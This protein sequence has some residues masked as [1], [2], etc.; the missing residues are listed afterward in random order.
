MLFF[1][2]KLILI[3]GLTI[4]IYFIYR[5]IESM[6]QRLLVMEKKP[7]QHYIPPISEISELLPIVNFTAPTKKIIVD[8]AETKPDMIDYNVMKQKSVDISSKFL[9]IYS[10]DNTSSL[11]IN[12]SI[13]INSPIQESIHEI[14]YE[15]SPKMQNTDNKI[16]KEYTTTFLQGLKMN[17]LNAIALENNIVLNKEQNGSFK[18]KLKV[19][20]INEIISK[21]K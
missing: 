3:I 17:E 1:D 15:T 16:K 21:T 9:E 6:H 18:K 10:N 14:V 5:E 12:D 20:L 2:F 19:D 4:V 8:F 7:K 13:H 11:V